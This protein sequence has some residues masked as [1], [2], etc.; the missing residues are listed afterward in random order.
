MLNAIVGGGRAERAG[1][2]RFYWF[3][4]NEQRRWKIYSLLTESS[5]QCSAVFLSE[6][7]AESQQAS[8]QSTYSLTNLLALQ[9]A[10]Y[11]YF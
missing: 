7:S 5:T 11:N 1:E 2:R 6:Y 10:F 4:F 9:T 3:S 8:K